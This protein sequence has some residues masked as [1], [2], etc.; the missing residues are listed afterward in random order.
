MEREERFIRIDLFYTQ[1]NG[2][3][4]ERRSMNLPSIAWMDKPE[5]A[6]K[7]SNQ[8]PLEWV[9][10]KAFQAFLRTLLLGWD[11]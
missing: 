10:G 7:W 5:G 9:N 6:T 4:P 3:I 8:N 1:V 2:S 11:F